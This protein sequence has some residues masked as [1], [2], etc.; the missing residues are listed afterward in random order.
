[1]DYC[2]PCRRHLNG[3]LS[4]PGCGAPAG[5][6]PL[7]A[8]TVLPAATPYASTAADRRGRRSR[9]GRPTGRRRAA[10]LT[11][12]GLALGGAG[13]LALAAPDGSGA[14][15]PDTVPVE[16]TVPTAGST[17]SA[18]PATTSAA[19]PPSAPAPARSSRPAPSRSATSAPSSARPSAT[20]G[21]PS[22]APTATASATPGRS[23]G[24]SPSASCKP[25]LFWCT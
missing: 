17:P 12:A 8:T 9:R 15:R 16:A 7:D 20:T 5:A 25:V 22:P 13:V 4:C 19:P 21:V 2:A 24:H 18:A 1:M 6:Q 10:L 11:A 14:A 3:A 23:P